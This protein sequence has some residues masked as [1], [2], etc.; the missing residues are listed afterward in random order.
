LEYV[1]LDGSVVVYDID[2]GHR[3]VDAFAIPQTVKGVRGVA[4]HPASRAMYLAYGGDGPPNGNGSVL[5]YDL[6]ARTVQWDRH[7]SHG[8]DSLAVSNDGST[9][10]VPS[11][12]QS[13]DGHWHLVNA[14]TGEETGAAIKAGAGPHNTVVGASGRVY[15]GSRDH[16]RLFVYDP[17]AGKIAKRVG[18]LKAG[19]RPFRINA[20]ETLAFTTATRFLGFQVSDLHTGKVLH[21]LTFKGFTWDP[22]TFTPSAPSHGITL[23]PDEREVYVV[24]GP[25]S[26]IHVFDVSGLPAVAPKPIADIHLAHKFAGHESPCAYDCA[27]DGWVQHSRDGRYV[28]VGDSGDVIDTA[29]KKIVAHLPA[30]AN[31]R[32]HVEIDWRDGVPVATTGR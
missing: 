32:K 11:G 12:E 16:P 3:Q 6:I 10:Y 23:S 15:L 13:R 20:R 5:R 21:T 14:A 7:Y 28:Y 4:V 2:D 26:V 1:V 19:V 9:L 31:T 22:S 30:M 25:N 27:R 17:V 24:D 18:E 8:V 29:T